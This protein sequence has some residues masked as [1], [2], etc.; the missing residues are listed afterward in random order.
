MINDALGISAQLFTLILVI[1]AI[2]M[3]YG[4]AWVQRKVKKVEY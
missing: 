2:G 4:A 3:F 1:V